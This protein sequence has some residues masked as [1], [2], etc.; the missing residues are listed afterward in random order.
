MLSNY[1]IRTLDAVSQITEIDRNLILSPCRKVEVVDARSLVVCVLLSMGFYPNN[2][3]QM[4]GLTRAGVYYL[5]STFSNRIK[6][7]PL[8]SRYL[9]EVKKQLESNT[10]AI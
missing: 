3:A 8:L 9:S 1:F 5:N 10:K 2:I 4:M 7:N 6:A